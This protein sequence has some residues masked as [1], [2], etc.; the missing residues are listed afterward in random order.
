MRGLRYACQRHRELF[1]EILKRHGA[2]DEDEIEVVRLRLLAW[3]SAN[4]PAMVLDHFNRKACLGCGLES[5][6]VDLSPM[7]EAI[8][9]SVLADGGAP[10]S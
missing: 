4:Y 8:R 10:A 2:L 9:H 7:R 6:C 5:A 3:L 1:F